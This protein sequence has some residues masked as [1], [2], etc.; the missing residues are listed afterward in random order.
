MRRSPSAAEG[1]DGLEEIAAADPSN[2]GND[3]IFL[4][5]DRATHASCSFRNSD[6]LL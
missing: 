3:D 4:D 5:E 6:C 1:L 2:N